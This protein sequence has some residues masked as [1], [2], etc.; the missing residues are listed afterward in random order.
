MQK[1]MCELRD[2]FEIYNNDPDI[3]YLDY[4]ATTFMPDTVRDAWL[5]YH[6]TI[7][8]SANR[9]R[10]WLGMKAIDYLDSSRFKISEFFNAD[11]SYDLIFTKNATE[12]L[13]IVANGFGMLL[14]EGDIILL[15]SLEHHSNMLPWSKIA[16]EKGAIIV[17]IPLNE[18]GNLDYE[19][20]NSLKGKNVKLVSIS[21][22]SNVTGHQID[23]KRIKEF[24]DEEQAYCIL[25][26]S[27][28]VAHQAV[29]LTEYD[30]DAYA[31][32]AHKM[33]GPKNIG[34]LFIKKNHMEEIEPYMYG[35]GMVWNS[36]G[37]KK[38]WA[39]GHQ[40]FEAGT[41]DVGLAYAWSKACEF[42]EEIR[43]EN[44]EKINSSI[45]ERIS[46]E[47][48][49]IKNIEIIKNG[50]IYAKSLLTFEHKKLH[51]H[52]LESELSKRNIIIRTG[53]MCS[54][55]MLRELNKVS[56]N[57]VSWGIGITNKDIETFI[58]AIKELDKKYKE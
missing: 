47:L 32:S 27:Q 20:L 58:N 31:L 55:N 19:I 22:V 43:F 38:E 42:I 25:D 35:G 9:N 49:N 4:S 46:G 23:Y 48:S 8:I 2:E 7:S 57:R 13:N 34:G 36:G 40:K 41:F 17:S 24:V 54:Q 14:T 51:S 53:H 37:S 21:L 12:S 15:S 26:I 29:D 18:D 52:D 56:L 44:I 39:E 6:S 1:L 3:T 33:Y 50:N 10:S 45:Y 30:A 28:A 16:K 5:K 11:D